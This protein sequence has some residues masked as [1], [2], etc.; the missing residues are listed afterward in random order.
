MIR[1]ATLVHSLPARAPCS[2]Q[3]AYSQIA[4]VH[5][6]W[7]HVCRTPSHQFLIPKHL[8]NVSDVCDVFS[9]SLS[10]VSLVSWPAFFSVVVETGDGDSAGLACALLPDVV[11]GE[12]TTKHQCPV[13]TAHGVAVL[14]WKWMSLSD[15]SFLQAFLQVQKGGLAVHAVGRVTSRSQ[16]TWL[17]FSCLPIALQP[18]HRIQHSLTSSLPMS[19]GWFHLDDRGCV[20]SIRASLG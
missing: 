9:V 4:C 1:H 13:C 11:P 7:Q 2:L 3:Q 5:Q 16:C 19:L 8:R 14:L 6:S 12:R 15:G 10:V 17:L 18:F 20:L